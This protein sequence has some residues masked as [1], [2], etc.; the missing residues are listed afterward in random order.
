MTETIKKDDIKTVNVFDKY[1]N[2]L[3]NETEVDGKSVLRSNEYTEDGNYPKSSTDS[4]GFKTSYSYDSNTGYLNS[5]TDA[6]G[7]SVNYSYN[8]SGKV[9]KVSQ[10][11]V[12][13]NSFTYDS[14]DRLSKI[15][16]ND[17]DYDIGYTEFGLLKSIKAGNG[18]LINY[19]Y[20]SKGALTKTDYG[21][22]QSIDYKYNE[23]GS[24][25]SVKQGDETLYSCKYDKDGNLKSVQDNCSNRETKYSTDKD[26]YRVTEETGSGVYH[27]IYCTN[28]KLTEIIGEKEKTLQTDL[29]D[30]SYKVYW[31]IANNIYSTYFNSKDKFGRKSEEGVY[32]I[33]RSSN[34]KEVE[35]S[36]KEVYNK[37]YSY[38]SSSPNR[39]S[40]LVSEIKYTGAYNNT[41]HYGYDG[42]KRISEVND[43]CYT[44]DEAGH[45]TTEVNFITRTGVNFVYDKGGNVVEII[46]F[47]RGRYG[48]SHTFTYGDANWKDLLTAYNGNE[49]TYDEI[50]NPLTYY[51]GTEFSWTIG[52]RLKSALRSDGVKIKY[53]YNA[54]GLRTSKTIHNVKF[55]YFWNGDK[56]TAQTC[57]DNTWYFRYDGD[58]PIGFE[59]NDSQYYYVTDLLGSII[60]VLDADGEIAA[61]YSYDAWGN[62]TIINNKND[63]AYT[64]PLRFKGYYYDSDTGLYCIQSRYYDS[65][66]GRYIN[67]NSAN[68]VLQGKLNLFEYDTNPMKYVC[69]QTT[70]LSGIGSGGKISSS[71]DYYDVLRQGSSTTRP[72]LSYDKIYE[73]FIFS[74]DEFMVES[75]IIKKSLGNYIKF[76]YGFVFRVESANEFKSYWNSITYADVIVLNS[77]AGAD[78]IFNDL[79][80]KDIRKLKKINCKALI[81]LGCN[82]GHYTHIWNNIAYEFSQKISGIT[83]ASDGTV[84]SLWNGFDEPLFES[85]D[86]GSY[87]YASFR[88]YLSAKDKNRKNLGWVLYKTNNVNTTWYQTNIKFITLTSILDYLQ[89]IGFVKF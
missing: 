38:V 44:Y 6:E 88:Y 59:Y 64:N 33:Y 70:D 63:I 60:A 12:I 50:G 52:R 26:G 74:M 83:V 48:Q 35:L 47:S 23:N 67:A 37:E 13:E 62:C 56:L 79:Y 25:S 28:E 77:H 39:T 11:T 73:A 54:D 58:T 71:F 30:N 27:K 4:L 18:N 89:N 1:G 15:I 21:N 75:E 43:V 69:Q 19:S 32:G 42:N 46:P 45:L 84:D 66:T 82:A 9:Q 57:G 24:S 22:G 5:I 8:N 76:L 72:T 78:V 68:A 16:H 31:T 80:M 2:N 86:D 51:N 17:F 34:G 36:K 81:I 55:N 65:K 14:G 85:Y 3:R 40:E 87:E 53:T 41:I 10:G 7:N 61:E 49:I 29:G 20:D